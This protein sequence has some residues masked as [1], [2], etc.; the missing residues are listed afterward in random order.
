MVVLQHVH[1]YRAVAGRAVELAAAALADVAGGVG[2]LPAVDEKSRILAHAQ[3][4]AVGQS[5]VV[6]WVSVTET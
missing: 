4:G 1:A 2:N 6:G 5:Q 3:R